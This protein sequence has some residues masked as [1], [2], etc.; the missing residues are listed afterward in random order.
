MS[1]FI[2]NKLIEKFKEK[3]YFTREELLEFFKYY[4]PDLK[5]GTFGW[6]IYDLKKKD[7]IKPLKRGLYT[8]SYKPKFRP[9]LPESLFKLARQIYHRYEDVRFCIW[10]S[11]WLNEFAQHQTSRSTIFIE[12]ERGFEESVFY[13]IRDITKNQLFLNPH[14]KEIDLYISESHKPIVIRKLVSRAPLLK[15]TERKVTYYTPTLEKL[16]VDLYAEEKLFNYLQGSEMIHIYENAMAKYTLNFTR[17]F[18]YAKR[19]EREN[20]IKQFM[21]DN[22]YHLVKEIIG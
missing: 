22:T 20:E 16:L 15:R 1:K 21:I 12:I 10:E 9:I 2:E 19:R 7:I 3:E 6:R 14:E 4:E 8:I 11:G 5:E 18:S 13:D 17:L